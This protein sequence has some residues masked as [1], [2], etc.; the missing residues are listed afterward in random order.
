MCPKLQKLTAV[1]KKITIT[2]IWHSTPILT[3]DTLSK[4]HEPDKRLTNTCFLYGIK[5]SIFY[6]LVVQVNSKFLL[7]WLP[8]LI[9][10]NELMYLAWYN[11]LVTSMLMKPRG[12]KLVKK[13]RPWNGDIFK[14]FENKNNKVQNNPWL[15]ASSLTSTDFLTNIRITATN[16]VQS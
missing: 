1:K 15:R 13:C 2:N 10:Y 5:P 16:Y 6:F 4:W 8:F 14:L 11:N 12:R 9:K 3:F 7:K